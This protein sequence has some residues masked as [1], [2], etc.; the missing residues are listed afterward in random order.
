MLPWRLSSKESTCQAGDPG[1]IPGSGRSPR[2]GDGNPLPYS[3]LEN[4]M[5]RGAW[6]ATVHGVAI[7]SHNLAT[8]PPHHSL[9]IFPRLKSKGKGELTSFVI[10]HSGIIVLQCL[11]LVFYKVIWFEDISSRA[12]PVT[13]CWSEADIPV[14]LKIIFKSFKYFI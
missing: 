12:V 10:H 7:V 6:W 9:N 11:C 14:I 13:P 2:E 1:F 3:C 5:H 4:S 8:K